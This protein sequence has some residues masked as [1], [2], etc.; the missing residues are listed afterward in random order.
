MQ[1]RVGLDYLS[2]STCHGSCLEMFFVSYFN[3][4]K[5]PL[6]QRDAARDRRNCMLANPSCQSSDRRSFISPGFIT[7]RCRSL[8]SKPPGGRRGG[9]KTQEGLVSLSAIKDIRMDA[10]LEAVSVWS[11]LHF[12]PKMTTKN[13]TWAS[14]LC[15]T[16]FHLTN[17]NFLGQETKYRLCVPSSQLFSTQCLDPDKGKTSDLSAWMC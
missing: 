4:R 13:S 12:H 9:E 17:S 5:S 11:V 15:T 2:S 16:C 6:F 14:F 8:L 3:A 7:S 1:Q 10:A